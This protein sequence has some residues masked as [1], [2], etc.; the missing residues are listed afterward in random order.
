M[1]DQSNRERIRTIAQVDALDL[2]YPG[3]MVKG[4]LDGFYDQPWPKI[5]PSPAYEHGRRNGVADRTGESD[6]DQR[7]VARDYVSRSRAA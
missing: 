7:A 3:D 1:S 4:Y 2:Q 6:D 5:D